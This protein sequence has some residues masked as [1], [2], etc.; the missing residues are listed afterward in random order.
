MKSKPLQNFSFLRFGNVYIRSKDFRT[1]DAQR[2]E[3]ILQNAS[4]QAGCI[5]KNQSDKPFINSLIEAVFAEHLNHDLYNKELI[6][7]M[8][9]TIIVVVARNIAKYVL[10]AVK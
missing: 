7:K 9:D 3:Y 6:T 2:M 4:H 1:D 5:L 10:V 8:I